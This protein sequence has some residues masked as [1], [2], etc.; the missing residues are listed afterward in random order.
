MKKGQKFVKSY[1]TIITI[2]ICLSV[3]ISPVCLYAKAPTIDP[4]DD[5]SH[6]GPP[7]KILMWTPEQQVAGYRNMNKLRPTRKISAGGT[8]LELPQQLRDLG[9]FKIKTDGQ[10]LTVDEY[11]VQ[12]NVAGLLVIKDGNIVYERYGLGN[13]ED[14]LW[15]AFSVAKSITSML[16]GAAVQEARPSSPTSRPAR[17]APGRGPRSRS[18]IGFGSRRR[19]RSSAASCGRRTA[20]RPEPGR[21]PT[22]RRGPRARCRAG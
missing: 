15:V 20:P 18:G 13:T 7:E 9:H 6:F 4:A 2:T 19:T 16:V 17:R 3:L 14:S 11:F 8:V 1:Q 10:S 21:W 12:Q 22:S 5:A